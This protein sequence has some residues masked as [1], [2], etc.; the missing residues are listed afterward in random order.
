MEHQQELLEPGEEA[1]APLATVS[2]KLLPATL[3]TVPR[4]VV[5]VDEMVTIQNAKR[6]FYQRVMIPDQHYGKIPGVTK[7]VLLK[8]GAELL[9]S[10]MGMHVELADAQSPIQDF[11]D[12]D[13]EGHIY[14]RRVARVY[15]QVSASERVLLVQAEGSCSSRE[16]KYRWRDSK[17]LCPTCGKDAIIK[18]KREYGGGWLCF[19]KKGGCGAKFKDGDATIEGQEVGRTLNDSLA[20]ID[21]TI[22]KMADKR[23]FVAACLLATG[24][25]DIFTQD[26]EDATGQAEPNEPPSSNGN[27]HAARTVDNAQT[28]AAGAKSCLAYASQKKITDEQRHEISQAFFARSSTKDLDTTELRTLYRLLTEW[29][30]ARDEK[31]AIF[32]DWLSS[33]I[34]EARLTAQDEFGD[35]PN[36]ES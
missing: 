28:R 36:G 3:S 26:V 25:S 8:P 6:E 16:T 13:R 35:P 7:D 12:T 31:G 30:A 21:N 29:R 18:G 34:G 4:F 10:A 19:G 2:P 14:Y 11:G 33:T 20:D 32:A 23:A 22:L 9:F 24:C 5:P 15:R 17:R 1:P 27:G